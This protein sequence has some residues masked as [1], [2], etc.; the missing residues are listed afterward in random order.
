MPPATEPRFDFFFYGTL[1][2]ADVRAVV[3][4]HDSETAPAF[5]DNHEAVPVHGGRYPILQFQR[6]SMATGVLCR[7]L[8]LVAAARLS[9]F[10]HDGYDYDPRRL[11]VSLGDRAGSGGATQPAWVF[12]PTTAL[13]R[14]MGR[15]DL[16]EWQR[17]A[18]RDF[19]ARATRKM[20]AL[21][22][23]QLE[24]YIE[25]W[26]KRAEAAG[27]GRRDRISRGQISRD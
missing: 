17:F 26:K 10:E 13:R 2:D 18:K 14:G 25:Q 5:L 4:G 11:T 27:G 19:L 21:E 9:F 16:S 24:P 12:V 8:G 7:N 3:V 23:K 20:R 22:P 15:W 6:G 1:C